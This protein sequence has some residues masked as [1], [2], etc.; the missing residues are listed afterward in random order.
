MINSKKVIIHTQSYLR[1]IEQDKITFCKSDN[2]Y[3]DIVLADGEKIVI[4]KPLSKFLKELCQEKFVKVSQSY[5]V[6]I[7]YIRLV[8]KKKRTIELSNRIEI[9]FTTSIKELLSLIGSTVDSYA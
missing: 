7:D 5:L 2:C 4:S 3:T 9:P 1:I 8:D 6:N